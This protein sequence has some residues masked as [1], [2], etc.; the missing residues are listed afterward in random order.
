MIKQFYEQQSNDK[1]ELCPLAI[2]S[3]GNADG[4][5]RPTGR[6]ATGP[7]GFPHPI[8]VQW[9]SGWPWKGK[10][11]GEG[12]K[13][14]TGEAWPKRANKSIAAFT[15]KMEYVATRMAFLLSRYALAPGLACGFC[16]ISGQKR[17][18]KELQGH[19]IQ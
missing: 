10:K 12:Q 8:V 9:S 7:A 5:G 18:R 1:S 2:C 14:I 16:L 19:W 11:H 13:A 3:L 6:L 15:I 4:M 17:H